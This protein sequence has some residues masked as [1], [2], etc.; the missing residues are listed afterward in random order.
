MCG[1]A[2]I[3]LRAC[4]RT[5]AKQ[6]G[7]PAGHSVPEAGFRAR[8]RLENWAPSL[9]GLRSP[10]QARRAAALRNDTRVGYSP[11]WGGTPRRSQKAMFTVSTNRWPVSMGAQMMLCCE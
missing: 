2:P 5:I 8:L 4:G 3:L 1:D 10:E 11:P 6:H 9:R 7:G